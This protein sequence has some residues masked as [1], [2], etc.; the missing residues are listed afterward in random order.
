MT[1]GA[2]TRR[3]LLQQLTTRVERT[4]LAEVAAVSVAT[5]LAD[6]TTLIGI[7]ALAVALTRGDDSVHVAGTQ[8]GTT[9]LLLVSRRWPTGL[10]AT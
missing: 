4:M 10:R 1:S 9:T 5:G 7:S 2:T 3:S 6:A 8:W